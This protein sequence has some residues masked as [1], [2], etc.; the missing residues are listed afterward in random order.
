MPTPMRSRGA[1]VDMET[2]GD[3]ET[4]SEPGATCVVEGGVSL[5]REI[6]GE[7]ILVMSGQAA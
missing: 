1:V 2:S 7:V 6:L 5:L 4:G 3:E